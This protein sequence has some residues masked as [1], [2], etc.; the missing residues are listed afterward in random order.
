ML[1]K[2]RDRFEMEIVENAFVGSGYIFHDNLNYSVD[3]ESD[4]DVE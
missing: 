4:S 1:Q 3:T 2:I